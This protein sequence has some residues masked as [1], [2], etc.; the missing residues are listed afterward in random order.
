[1][2]PATLSGALAALDRSPP[3]LA[4]FAIGL[5]G[6]VVAYAALDARTR[7][8]FRVSLR[9]AGLGATAMLLWWIWR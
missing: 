8:Y 2:S 4:L 5:V 6:I 9:L 1:M 7:G 3:R